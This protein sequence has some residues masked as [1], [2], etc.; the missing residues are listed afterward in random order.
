MKNLFSLEVLHKVG[1]KK[2][3]LAWI[4]FVLYYGFY[5]FSFVNFKLLFSEDK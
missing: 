5:Y 2:A 3:P 4:W 1:M